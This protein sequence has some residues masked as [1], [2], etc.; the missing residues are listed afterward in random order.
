M[1]TVSRVLNQ[2]SNVSATKVKAVRSAMQKV[3]YEPRARGVG[4]KLGSTRAPSS[5]LSAFALVVPE[6]SRGLYWSLQQGF[7]TKANELHH[8]VLVCNTNNDV[9]RQA[10]EILQLVCKNVAGVAIV[11]VTSDPTPPA[12]VEVLQK[13]G[14]PVVV[15][16]RA[17]EGVEAPQIDLPLERIG[18]TAGWTAFE[19]GHRRVA[20]LAGAEN[21]SSRLHAAGLRRA[22]RE[23]GVDLADELL[24]HCAMPG[25]RAAAENEAAVSEQLA[26]LWNM[27]VAERPTAIYAPLDWIAEVV[28]LCLI[29]MGLRVPQDVSLLSFGDAHR[30]GAIARRLTSVVVDES[31]AG[32]L[33]VDL[34]MEMRSGKCSLSDRRQFVMSLSLSK[35]ETLEQASGV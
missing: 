26:R 5:M 35:G 4:R 18:Y 6:V 32:S 28:Y 27:P 23:G 12:H 8:Q 34:F 17:I 24:V 3:R 1:A 14:I 13:A 15:L 9:Y 31:C 25:E 22:L 33:A 20:F 19:K 11:S 7:A 10:D 21:C 29:R 30:D 2:H 16:H